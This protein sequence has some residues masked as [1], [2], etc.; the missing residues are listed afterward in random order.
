MLA[1]AEAGADAVDLAIDAMS[2]TTSQP[3]LGAVVGAL[4]NHPTLDTGLDPGE[5]NLLNEYWEQ[6]RE[7]YAPF[8]SGQKSG[9]ADARRKTFFPNA[10]ERVVIATAACHTHTAMSYGTGISH[11][12]VVR[13]LRADR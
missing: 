10:P 6:C 7:V 8:E 1:C 5:I 11:R 2:G 12:R 4:R 3:S 9:S 13:V